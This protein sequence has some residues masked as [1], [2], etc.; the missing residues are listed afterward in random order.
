MSARQILQSRT[1]PCRQQQIGRVAVCR[2]TEPQ[3]A[4][5][6]LRRRSRQLF[7]SRRHIARGR[8]IARI[9][10]R[11]L[12]R[13]QPF[14]QAQ[15]FFVERKLFQRIAA[16]LHL[17]LVLPKPD[18]DLRFLAAKRRQLG[19]P[20]GRR[21]RQHRRARQFHA[22]RTQPAKVRQ[23]LDLRLQARLRDSKFGAT[24]DRFLMPV[25]CLRQ[26]LAQRRIFACVDVEGISLRPQG[27]KLR[28]QLCKLM[29]ARL[30][31]VEGVGLAAQGGK[32][33][34]TVRQSRACGKQQRP[35][36]SLALQDRLAALL[37]ALVIERKHCLIG[38]AIDRAQH[39]GEEIVGQRLVVDADQRVR[40]AFDPEHAVRPISRLDGAT[41]PH[42][43]IGMQEPI[44]ARVLDPEEQ[45]EEAREHR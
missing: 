31:P 16:V 11:L 17:A 27:V 10:G 21:D 8:D 35:K 6:D 15:P 20:L 19:C 12:Q 40:L 9:E 44:G 34:R 45:I 26:R 41:D 37:D 43:R 3:Q 36:L 33:R 24:C 23:G 4:T 22:K 1:D 32:D 7:Q 39:T 5:D 42:C 29:L 18:L 14:G 28:L 13:R 38:V 2:F 30:W 25:A